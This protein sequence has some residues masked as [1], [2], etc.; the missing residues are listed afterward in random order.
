MHAHSLERLASI[1]TSERVSTSPHVCART[2]EV[3][4]VHA[5]RRSLRSRAQV[6]PRVGRHACFDGRWLHGAPAVLCPSTSKPYRRI[7]FCVNLWVGHK[8]AGCNRFSASSKHV[9][10]AAAKDDDFASA[11]AKAD[12]E[13]KGSKVGSKS[14]S[15]AADRADAAEC[16]SKRKV[17]TDEANLSS[18]ACSNTSNADDIISART[19]TVA[20]TAKATTAVAAHRRATSSATTQSP[21]CESDAFHDGSIL[22][23]L[24]ASSRAQLPRPLAPSPSYF[25]GPILVRAGEETERIELPVHQT[26]QPHALWIEVP[27]RAR[28]RLAQRLVVD[29]RFEGRRPQDAFCR[30]S[31]SVDGAWAKTEQ[32]EMEALQQAERAEGGEVEVVGATEAKHVAR[33]R[34]GRKR[35]RQRS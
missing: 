7:T 24:R 5:C 8:P 35:L 27:A 30:I 19:T 33:K 28:A 29:L 31:E 26:R 9:A 12:G 17:R 3:C 20:A 22:F 21:L 11:R 2:R 34:D 23:R 16:V 14:T 18:S 13:G 10:P 15:D 1:R 4:V 32:P 25:V 6:P